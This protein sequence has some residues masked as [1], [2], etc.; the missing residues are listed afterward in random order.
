MRSTK[1]DY[2][3]TKRQLK[4]KRQAVKTL[5]MGDKFNE[6]SNKDQKDKD[7]KQES[8][9][10]G[11]RAHIKFGFDHISEAEKIVTCSYLNK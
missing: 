9:I 7:G 4:N 3:T 5:Q 6:F 1:Q 8:K 11:N 2:D 10:D